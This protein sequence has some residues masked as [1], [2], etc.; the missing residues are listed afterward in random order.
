MI[1]EIL[2][3]KPDFKTFHFQPFIS[4]EMAFYRDISSRENDKKNPKMTKNPEYRVWIK[5]TEI[6]G[7]SYLG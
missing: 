1:D 7:I 2:K 3:F 5:N 6:T 4:A